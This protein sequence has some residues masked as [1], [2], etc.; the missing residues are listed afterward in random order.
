MGFITN[1][2][3]GFTIGYSPDGLVGE[4]GAI[5]AKSRRQKFQV[6]TIIEHVIDDF[7]ASIPAEFLIQVQTG[8]LVT[9]RNW[10]DFVSY[11]GGLPM[12]TIRVFPDPVIQAA[13]IDAASAFEERLAKA[14]ATYREA[15]TNERR[16]IPTER[17][18]EQEMFV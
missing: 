7:S 13:I 11:C 5:E 12:C 6:Q 10:M 4:D 2:R 8:L 18:I 15:I 14:L 3:W 1:R 17:R 16:F 9:E